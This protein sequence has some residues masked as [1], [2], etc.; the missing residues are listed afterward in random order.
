MGDHHVEH[1]P[2]PQ[3]VHS[4]F[5]QDES[6][7]VTIYKMM[8]SKFAD[9][10]LR[11]INVS[12]LRHFHLNRLNDSERQEWEEKKAKF[13]NL[14]HSQYRYQQQNGAK[15]QNEMEQDVPS[16][17]DEDEGQQ[18]PVRMLLKKDNMNGQNSKNGKT[19][20]NKS[21][22]NNG[23]KINLDQKQQKYDKMKEQIFK[24]KENDENENDDDDELKEESMV[25][26][27]A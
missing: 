18:Q 15:N 9:I 16:C 20:Q 4:M 22:N 25:E 17:F 1:V 23:K 13:G 19:K 24:K 27:I 7:A 3:N 6:K 21:N 8:D 5:A 2:M 14:N 11:D 10:H 26:A 12:A